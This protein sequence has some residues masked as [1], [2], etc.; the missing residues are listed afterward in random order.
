[1][2]ADSA[3]P[4]RTLPQVMVLIPTFLN[5]KTGTVR[6]LPLQA[7]ESAAFEARSISVSAPAAFWGDCYAALE[8]LPEDSDW[9]L[10]KFIGFLAFHGALRLIE[11][12][13]GSQPPCN[14]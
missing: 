8:M 1:V 6:Q 9:T 13:D 10:G 12:A 5:F 7:G 4:R 2:T 14:S 11:T 3:I